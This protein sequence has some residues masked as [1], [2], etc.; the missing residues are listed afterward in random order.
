MASSP[1]QAVSSDFA[2]QRIHN[3]CGKPRVTKT[4]KVRKKLRAKYYKG[5]LRPRKKAIQD[6]ITPLIA[7][8]SSSE[9]ATITLA[10]ATRAY[11]EIAPKPLSN[12]GASSSMSSTSG[13]SACGRVGVRRSVRRSAA[14]NSAQNMVQAFEALVA[15]H[16]SA[17]SSVGYSS[18]YE[19]RAR[20]GSPSWYLV[21]GQC[22]MHW[23]SFTT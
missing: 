15:R 17:R 8:L 4:Y 14:P 3:R 9:S 16:P 6:A 7:S 22:R 12:A 1:S 20:G 18:R 5:K 13:A 11:R 2:R 10:T 23:L 19:R 21:I